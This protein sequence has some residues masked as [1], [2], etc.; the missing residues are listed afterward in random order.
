M[1]VDKPRP[2]DLIE[3]SCPLFSHW[4]IYVGDG[5]IV[6]L[7]NPS[8]LSGV[9]SASIGSNKTSKAKVKMELL[10]MVVGGY[11]YQ[12]NNK[13][14]AKYTPLPPNMIVRQ[15]K[16]MVGQELAYDLISHNCEHFVKNLRYRIPHSDQVDDAV[17]ILGVGA[18][19]VG[20]IRVIG[21]LLSKT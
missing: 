11:K 19:V 15:A 16:E 7:S 3:I 13:D 4:A 1:S 8:G 17:M 9:S 10:S 18:L 2:G 20:A 21:S 14:D 6:H 5:Y 12:I